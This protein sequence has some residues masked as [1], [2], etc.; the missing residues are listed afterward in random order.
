MHE[1]FLRAYNIF[2]RL[3]KLNICSIPTSVQV[4][5]ENDIL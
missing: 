3:Y 4:G 1:Q 5:L 2:I